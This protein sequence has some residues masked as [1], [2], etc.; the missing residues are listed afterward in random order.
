MT[1]VEFRGNKRNG[2]KTYNK[3]IF[4]IGVLFSF[5]VWADILNEV[6]NISHFGALRFFLCVNVPVLAFDYR[7]N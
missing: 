7:F 5:K 6:P 4:K 3:I 2:G 1:I